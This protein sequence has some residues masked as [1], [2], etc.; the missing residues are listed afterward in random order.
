MRNSRIVLC[1]LSLLMLVLAVACVRTESTFTQSGRYSNDDRDRVF[2]VTF[3]AG[4]SEE[5]MR[6]YGMRAT[7][8]A[9]RLTAVFFYPASRPNPGSALSSATSLEQAIEV[10]SSGP[11]PAYVYQRATNGLETFVNCGREVDAVLC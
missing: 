10:L 8:T 6:S 1:T 2:A 4:T 11:S 9:G 5:A 7:N 3:P